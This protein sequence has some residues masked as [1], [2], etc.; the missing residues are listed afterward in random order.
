[1]KK[2]PQEPWCDFLDRYLLYAETCTEVTDQIKAVELFRKLP[3]D[4][5]HQI[6][7]L[8]PSATLEE[9]L[10]ALS[11]RSILGQLLR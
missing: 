9:L 10:E 6:S 2:R 1:M 5:H 4:M 11:G 8:K 3:K 7:Y